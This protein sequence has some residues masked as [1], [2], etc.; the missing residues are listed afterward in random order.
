MHTFPSNNIRITCLLT[1]RYNLFSS[2][3]GRA[4]N[5]TPING[6]VNLGTD[7]PMYQQR[8]E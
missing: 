5:K 1:K 2:V 8:A 6:T 4:I 3:Q 7:T